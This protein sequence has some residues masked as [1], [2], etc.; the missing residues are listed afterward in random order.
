MTEELDPSSSG[1]AGLCKADRPANMFQLL[2]GSSPGSLRRFRPVSAEL[3]NRART[4]AAVS[5]GN[6][7]ANR[8]HSGAM[9]SPPAV[10]LDP[11]CMP[12]T[13]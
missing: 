2:A 7:R 4:V 1:C 3:R 5:G 8:G 12:F 10:G 11:F 13:D 6:L 9:S